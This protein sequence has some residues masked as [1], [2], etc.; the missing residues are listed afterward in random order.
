MRQTVFEYIEVDS[1]RNRRHS[2][3]GCISPRSISNPFGKEELMKKVLALSILIFCFHLTMPVLAQESNKSKTTK[4]SSSTS[5]REVLVNSEL[6]NKVISIDEYHSHIL[7]VISAFGLSALQIPGDFTKLVISSC[8]TRWMVKGFDPFTSKIGWVPYDG[9]SNLYSREIED[10]V[11]KKKETVNGA[12]CA[13][14]FEI[15]DVWGT[16]REASSKGYFYFLPQ[17]FMIKHKT[18]QPNSYKNTNIPSMPAMLPAGEITSLKPGESSKGFFAALVGND[19]PDSN[20]IFHYLSLLC[21]KNSGKIRGLAND[22]IFVSDM[23]G[24]IIKDGIRGFWKDS[25]SEEIGRAHV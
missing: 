8:D 15:V 4:P 14:R 18:P 23:R 24:H 17:S 1:N 7:P 2:A 11:T 20:D 3:N 16:W 25:L 6:T 5:L 12:I 13:D 22:G 21:V 9:K 19:K 10:K